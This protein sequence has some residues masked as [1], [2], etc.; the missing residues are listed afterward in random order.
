MVRLSLKQNSHAIK[1]IGTGKQ[2]RLE[3]WEKLKLRENTVLET[4]PWKIP[5]FSKMRVM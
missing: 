3:T 1:L 5:S 2:Q 4:E